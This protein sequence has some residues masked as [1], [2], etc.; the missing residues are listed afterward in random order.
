MRNQIQL[1]PGNEQLTK[2]AGNEEAACAQ[3]L[4]LDWKE[5]KPEKREH[6][7]QEKKYPKMGSERPAETGQRVLSQTFIPMASEIHWSLVSRGVI[8]HLGPTNVF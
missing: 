4:S 5:R 7:K 3:G 6:N 1:N 8:L 2:W